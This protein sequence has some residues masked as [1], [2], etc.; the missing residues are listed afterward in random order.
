MSWKP[1]KKINLEQTYT[2]KQRG[3]YFR[4]TPEVGYHFHGSWFALG[5][6]KGAMNFGLQVEDREL[7][8]RGETISIFRRKLGTISTAQ[9]CS[10]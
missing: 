1:L 7:G 6:W 3:D 5:G 10:W 8:N 9:V 4:L 2:W